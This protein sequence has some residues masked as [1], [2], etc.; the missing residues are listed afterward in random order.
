[1]IPIEFKGNEKEIVNKLSHILLKIKK[2]Q[3]NKKEYSDKIRKINDWCKNNIIIDGK[4]FTFPEIIKAD[5]ETLG[6]IVKK[7]DE[8]EEFKYKKYM[9]DKLYEDRFPRQE[10]VESLGVTV[11]PYCNRNFVNSTT[12]RTMCELEHF[13][14]KEKYPLLAVSFYNLVPV[15]HT[16]NHVKGT[17]DISYSPHDKKYEASDLIDFDFYLKGMDYLHDPKDIGIEI[18]ASK[19]MIQNVKVLQL[20]K[21]YQIHT[22]VVQECIKKAMIFNPEYLDYLY[23]EYKSLFRTKEELYRIIFGNHIEEESFGK[24]PLAKLTHD[25][26]EKLYEM[27]GIDI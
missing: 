1:M 6:E 9:I 7:L 23:T 5:F 17:K 11:C 22:D 19:R 4:R 21:V 12:E 13:Y 16:C 14:R 18:D 25:V 27:Y 3:H 10:F 20:D 26:L 24:R 15:C 8:I 2:G